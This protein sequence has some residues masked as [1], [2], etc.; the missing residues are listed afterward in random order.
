MRDYKWLHEYCL[1]RFGSAAALEAE[2]P[3]PCTAAQLRQLGDDR[4]LSM[5][6]LR[7]FRAG[8]KH[9]LVDAKWPVF[10]QVFFGFDPEKVVLMGAEHLERLMQDARIIR[11]LGKLKSVP[12]NAQMVLDVAR[13][14]GSFGNLIADWPVTE[15]TG[16]WKYLA[17]HG[18]QL[19]G[20]SAPRLLR[21]VGKDTFVPSYDVVA[22]LNAQKIVDKV[23]T[24]LRDLAI[25]QDA[26]N[27]WHVESGRPMCQLSM[28][29]AF[30]VNH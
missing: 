30:T 2:L 23:P 16:L 15:I 28:M 21:M 14:K 18:H 7:V 1:N 20:L 5:I 29:L 13:E 27:Q 26:F 4:Y 8:L 11:H 12:R 22:A 3:E 25:V 9:S 17:K 6:A 19:G 10:E 24:S